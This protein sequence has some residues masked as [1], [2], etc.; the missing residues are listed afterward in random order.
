[1]FAAM[2]QAL[3][4]FIILTAAL[5]FAA[6][7]TRAQTVVESAQIRAEM[8]T[9]R[10][11]VA[12]GESLWV[13][14][15]LNIAPGW[16]TYWR[17]PGDS[18]LGTIIDWTLPPGVTAGE[19][20]YPAPERIDYQG[21]MNFGFHD[22]VT[23]LTELK[24][25]PDAP[26]GT[27][28]LQAAATWL[29]CADVCIPED[30]AFSLPIKIATGGAQMNT[31]AGA[32]IAAAREALP[33]AAPWPVGFER[34]GDTLTLKAGPGL[35]TLP[36]SASFFPYGEEIILNPAPQVL[37]TAD[38]AIELAMQAGPAAPAPAEVD[39][40]LVLENG[41]Q[42]VGYVVKAAVAATGVQAAAQ[43]AAATTTAGATEAS[44]TLLVALVFA[45]LGGI[46]LNIMPCV[47]PVLAMKAMSFVARGQT[48]AAALRRDGLAYTAGVMVTFGVL[49]GALLG[50][51]AA[52]DAVGWG[53][54]LQSPAFVAA[55]AYVMLALGLNLSGVFNIG[56]SYG[57]G[58]ELTAKGGM[59]GSFFTGL[60]AVVVATPCTAPFMGTAIGF[61]LTQSPLEAIL[62][63][64]ALALGLA[65]PYLL[66][67]F[68]PGA[69]KK[70]PRPGAWMDRVKQ[71]LAFPLYAAAA[72]LV[73]VFAQQLDAG[74]LA[75]ALA[76]LVLV[77]LVAWLWGTAQK[78]T[79]TGRRWAMGG[80]VVAL[81]AT[82]GLTT[83]LTGRTAPAAAQES[84]T[85]AYSVARLAEL[86]AEGRPVF[87]NFTAAWCITCKVNE[88][89]ALTKTEV[90]DA[91]ARSN[92]V[93]MKGD[94][95]NRN[96]EISDALRAVGRDGVPLYLY[97]APGAAAPQ[98]LPQ[99]LTPSLV[100]E[101]LGG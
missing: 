81:I 11:T 36:A 26:V 17:T 70:M 66:L 39:G 99:V 20:Q 77:G 74:G 54:Q 9:E 92:T 37:K 96:A 53:F 7:P 85:E 60:L 58:Q 40:V 67:A 42:H 94:W 91:F 6:V 51:R 72:W 45:F 13:A 34:S 14:L 78:A 56:G 43:G 31:K 46:I 100:I 48:D 64:E 68:V 28:T 47:L 25:A 63:F 44:A 27:G 29:V 4:T 86:R 8:T 55:L 97:Y 35:S 101:T 15:T 93:Y 59:T 23:L 32:V 12:P 65:A 71:V 73:W 33:K 69:A 1:M 22:K 84:G 62:I 76:G 50:L 82:L 21:L 98:I 18:G 5:L 90:E 75:V 89:V 83:T 95:T 79:G 57:V 3:R 38:G 16:H 10:D 52:G 88:R 49:V 19:V 87:I 41:G 24:V 30:G 2:K 80:A 61:A